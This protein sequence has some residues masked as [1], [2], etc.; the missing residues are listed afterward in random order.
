MKNNDNVC[1]HA[2]AICA[3]LLW[4]RQGWVFLKVLYKII[5]TPRELRRELDKL[6]TRRR[7]HMKSGEAMNGVCC[8]ALADA[9]KHNTQI[10]MYLIIQ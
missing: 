4:F 1:P 9:H 10:P 2:V 8:T 5:G 3:V 6:L 7:K